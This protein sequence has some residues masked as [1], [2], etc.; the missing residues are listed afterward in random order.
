MHTHDRDHDNNPARA[1]THTHTRQVPK[2]GL[3]SVDSAAHRSLALLT[4]RQGVVLLQNNATEETSGSDA[5]KKGLLPLDVTKFKS[6]A[7]IGPNA[8]ATSNLLGGYHGSPPFTPISPLIAM[9]NAVVRARSNHHGTTRTGSDGE[10]TGS[11]VRYAKGCTVNG[12]KNDNST[13]AEAVRLAA[14]VDVVVMV[15][16]LCGNNYGGEDPSG[17]CAVQT[18]TE[19]VDRKSLVLPGSQ[20]QLLQQVIINCDSRSGV[21][22]PSAIAR[23]CA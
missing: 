18:E 14:E 1:H 15:L 21:T 9:Q 17:V 16:G 22:T 3:G 23:A 13:I 11:T 8:N 5:P 7:M 12:D 10:F 20:L 2:F 6:I 19:G 4:A